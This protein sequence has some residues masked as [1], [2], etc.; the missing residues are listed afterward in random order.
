MTK[1][2]R[3]VS[4]NLRKPPPIPKLTGIGFLFV[5]LSLVAFA[6]RWLR[7][8]GSVVFGVGLICLAAAD[9]VLLQISRTYT[10]KL[11]DRIIKL[12]MKKP[13]PNA[14][15]RTTPR[16][17]PVQAAQPRPGF[18]L[19][20]TSRPFPPPRPGCFPR[21]RSKIR[22]PKTMA[23]GIA[24]PPALS[25]FRYG[26]AKRMVGGHPRETT[27]ADEM[28]LPRVGDNSGIVVGRRTNSGSPGTAVARIDAERRCRAGSADEQQSL[29][30]AGD[31][32]T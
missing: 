2:Q 23:A 16:A 18:P 3:H 14:P 9:V 4:P 26:R 10:T 15:R 19:C 24:P 5:L 17:P 27:V 22:N 20:R 29:R 7:I 21:H 30:C 13:G 1:E 11:Q 28:G 32:P 12:E 6:L 31:H 8:G 25:S